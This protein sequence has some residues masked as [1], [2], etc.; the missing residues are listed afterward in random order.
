MRI[1]IEPLRI[2][3]SPLTDYS[4]LPFND[5]KKAKHWKIKLDHFLIKKILL[6]GDR[7]C[8]SASVSPNQGSNGSSVGRRCTGK[9]KCHSIALRSKGLKGLILLFLQ[10]NGA[11]D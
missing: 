10:C 5:D 7:R 3:N 9:G 11:V 2:S 8:E 4:T 1:Y 6:P